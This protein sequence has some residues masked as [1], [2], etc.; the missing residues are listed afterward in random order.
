MSLNPN[1]SQGYIFM[2]VG[3]IPETCFGFICQGASVTCNNSTIHFS[4]LFRG[5]KMVFKYSFLKNPE[6]SQKIKQLAEVPLTII[7]VY[8]TN[9]VAGA[10]LNSIL[11]RVTLPTL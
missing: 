6:I 4:A 5:V 7:P 9:S 11:A 1:L 2:K 10:D 3:R 8:F